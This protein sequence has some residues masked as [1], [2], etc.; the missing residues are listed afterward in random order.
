MK[1][2]KSNTEVDSSRSE[3]NLTPKIPVWDLP[4]IP[5][6]YLPPHLQLQRT[7]VICNKEAPTH[8]ENVQYSGAYAALEFDNMLPL[9]TLFGE[10]S[11]LSHC[12][13][14]NEKNII[15]FKLHTQ[16][17]SR[18]TVKSD[19]LQWLP[20]RTKTL[21]EFSNNPIEPKYSDI[22]ITKLGPGQEIELE[23]HAVKGMGKTHVKWS[24][25][26]TAWYRMLPEVVLLQEVEGDKVEELMKKCPVNEFD[27]ED[28][29]KVTIESTRTLPPEVLFAESVKILEDKCEGVITE[30]L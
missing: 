7:R 9:P 18:S 6:G 29:G 20:N 28:I 15:V 27:I 14:E 3:K 21:P 25:V 5:K 17:G 1:S 8:T 12:F 22:I 10:F 19:E 30:L 13:P 2:S 26:A 16:C 4:D 23:A 24:P 11:Y